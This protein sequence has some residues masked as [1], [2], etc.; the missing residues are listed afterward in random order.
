MTTLDPNVLSTITGGLS[1]Q[2]LRTQL[3][4]LTSSLS[5]AAASQRAN[6]NQLA[7]FAMV[8]MLARR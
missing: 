1:Q 8:A 7:T 4:T 2:A 5:D 6:A 3:T